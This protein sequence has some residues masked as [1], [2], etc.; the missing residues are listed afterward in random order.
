[1]NPTPDD[2]LTAAL[3]AQLAAELG[4]ILGGRNPDVVEQALGICL[5]LHMLSRHPR[6][7]RPGA[8][9]HWMINVAK[10]MPVI[11][12]AARRDGVTLAYPKPPRETSH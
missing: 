11:E 3:A 2:E 5:G 7:D 10:L 12:R 8:L 4:A 1:M 9:H 6:P